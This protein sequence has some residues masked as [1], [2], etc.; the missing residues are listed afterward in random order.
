[1]NRKLLS[2][3]LLLLFAQINFAQTIENVNKD[4]IT[5]E[6][7]KDAIVFL[8]ETSAEVNG[9]RTLENRI[10]FSAELA[11]LMWFEDEKEARAMFQVAINDF[12]QLFAQYDAQ[13]NAAGI[14]PNED[15]LYMSGADSAAQLTRKF[16]KA[17][18]VRQQIATA[19]SEHDPKL[20]LEFFYDTALVITNPEFR[21]VIAGRDAYFET[22]LL[23]QIAE[24]D[25][26]TALKYARKSLDKGLNYETVSLLKK[27]YEKEEDKGIS[28]GL[29]ILAKIKSGDS[30]P[31]TFYIL[32]SLLAAGSESYDSTRMETRKLPNFLNK[33]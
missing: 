5:P 16:I 33:I 6:M 26:D 22:N 23:Q 28:F 3:L 32:N 27:I 8:R 17:V 9:L 20:A 11:A 13:I 14:T 18:A 7:R 30:D 4:G 21:N 1:M 24:K 15:R 31:E 12:R 25:I 29:D 2:L 10:S 19:I